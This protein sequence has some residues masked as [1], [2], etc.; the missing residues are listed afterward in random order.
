MG[1]LAA[2]LA[3]CQ[4]R[5]TTHKATV[6]DLYAPKLRIAKTNDFT[7]KP[8]IAYRFTKAQLAR[9]A[10]TKLETNRFLAYVERRWPIERLQAFCVPANEPPELWQNL[11]VAKCPLKTDLYQ[12]EAT[13]FDRIWV[14]V[15]E[16]DGNN[17][18]FEDAGRNWHRWAYSL[19]IERG[20]NCWAIIE[21]LPND[22]MD[23]ANYM[24]T[25]RGA[26][27]LSIAAATN[28]IPKSLKAFIGGWLG[29]CYSVELRGGT[30][31]YSA[32]NTAHTPE[33]AKV[34]PTDQRWRE[35]RHSLDLISVWQWQ[36]NYANPGVYD[37][38]Q[39]VLELQ[40]EDRILMSHGSNNFPD[41]N[42]KP[43][44]SQKVTKAFASYAAAVKRLL[45][46]KEFQ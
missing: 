14:Y 7:G 39:W 23:S 11:V 43:S 35:F 31:Y 18:Y 4:A 20:R 33:F 38:T 42:G 32:T 44:G 46:G 22:F 29:P 37:G 40:Y 2:T 3:G 15:S 34:I 19:N 5:N 28:G 41:R 13:G 45:D 1:F 8:G 30:L 9:M 25:S 16:D 10:G 26:A 24:V 36:T 21:R 17:T 12:G 27:T 6:Q